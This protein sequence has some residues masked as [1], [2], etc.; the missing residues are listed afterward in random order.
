MSDT[1]LI[2]NESW[3]GT[4]IHIV[5]IGCGDIS[6]LS[7]QAQQA[8]NNAALIIGAPHHFESIT[9]QL[10]TNIT[11][12][13]QPYPQPLA[14][15]L[16]LLCD[17]LSQR[18][19][20]L[21]SGDALFYGIGTWLRRH[22]SAEHLCFHSNISSIQAAFAQIGQP[23]QNAEI[24]SLHGRPLHSLYAKLQPQCWYGVL[25]D[26][27]SH[28]AA[29]AQLLTTAGF[30]TAQLWIV[31]ALGTAQQ[32]VRQFTA[33]ALTETCL[34]DTLTVHPLHITLIQTGTA[35][36]THLPIFPGIADHHFDTGNDHNNMGSGML[37]KREVRLNIL[38][39]LAPQAN[40]IGWDVGAG[41]GGVAIEWARWNPHGT[42][43][44]IEQHPQ[45]FA[46]LQKNQ[47]LFGV[48]MNLQPILA[49][50]PEAL[51]PLPTPNAIFIG[52]SSGRL[53]EIL[54][55]CWQQLLP[56]GRLVISAITQST[57]ATLHH[58]AEQ[59]SV[60]SAS[61]YWSEIAVSRGEQ[62]AGQLILRPQLPVLLLQI[63][64][65]SQ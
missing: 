57:R 58:F 31:E 15:L 19:V 35:P 27:D 20:L 52:G 43:Y 30:G 22:F 3:I 65:S 14:N 12:S 6:T 24:V 28:P 13:Q 40:D 55:F 41:C 53:S 61:I 17:H 4:V 51:Q 5:S 1:R 32:Q 56:A 18:I 39:L 2:A 23:W 45:R 26:E 47:Q 64:K 10:S 37:S 29:I 21:A 44:A 54:A 42:V 63:T 25:T 9:P 7:A 33:N 46:S 11:A 49:A 59:L 50:A 16:P 48:V 60:T 36:T 38:S 8:I 34:S 62:L